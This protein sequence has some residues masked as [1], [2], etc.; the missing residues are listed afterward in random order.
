MRER[1]SRS[2]EEEL[3]RV[4]RELETIKHANEKQQERHKFREKVQIEVEAQLL[5]RELE[6]ERAEELRRDSTRHRI[7]TVTRREQH[8][9]KRIDLRTTHGDADK[10]AWKNVPHDVFDVHRG[11]D[12][13]FNLELPIHVDHSDETE[14]MARLRR[15][16]N[17]AEGK[18]HFEDHFETHLHHPLVLVQCAELLFDMGDYKSVQLLDPKPA[19]GSGF[20]GQPSTAFRLRQLEDGRT[21]F[22]YEQAHT[23]RRR[24]GRPQSQ[25]G[26][27]SKRKEDPLSGPAVQGDED[28]VPPDLHNLGSHETRIMHLNWR[29]LEALSIFHIKGTVNE[30][31]AAAKQALHAL[32]VHEE[33]SSAEVSR[34]V[35]C[36]ICPIVAETDSGFPFTDPNNLS[37][38]PGVFPRATRRPRHLSARG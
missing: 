38:T 30:A 18:S 22:V 29:L 1:S 20:P 6:A 12:L 4:R 19:F 5:R 35:P 9:Y 37:R 3:E 24:L 2:V 17:F 10:E 13:T 31:L 33:I 16:G 28:A 25:S 11:R 8:K 15:H 34:R 14:D 7:T 21:R 36:C 32:V 26:N 23:H 27:R